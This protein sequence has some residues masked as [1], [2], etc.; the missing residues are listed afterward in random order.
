MHIFIK[1][2]ITHHQ[3]KHFYT[4][5]CSF[6][7]MIAH[8]EQEFG[9]VIVGE[10]SLATDNCTMWLNGLNDNFPGFPRLPCNYIPCSKP[11]MGS[12]QPGAP[13]DPG[14]PEHGPFGTGMVMDFTFAI[15]GQI[16][17]ISLELYVS[18]E[19][20]MGSKWQFE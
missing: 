14:K 5:S 6:K 15:I 17:M 7:G 1:H 2:G 9:P 11:Y 3:E 12:E 10:W 8:M 19:E 4:N 16:W 20:R 18:F 13:V